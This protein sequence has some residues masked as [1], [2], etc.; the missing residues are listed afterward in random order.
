MQIGFG[1]LVVWRDIRTS[2]CPL[3]CH[4][5]FKASVEIFKSSRLRIDNRHLFRSIGE[6]PGGS[7]DSLSKDERVDEI[8]DLT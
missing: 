1:D 5:P 4:V 2:E 3:L 6:L 7:S 8:H